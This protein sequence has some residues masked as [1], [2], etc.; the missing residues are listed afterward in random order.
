MADVSA[1]FDARLRGTRSGG[2]VRLTLLCAALIAS[3]LALVPAVPASAAPG[4]VTKGSLGTPR[5]SLAA[6]SGLDGRIYAFGGFNYPPFQEFKTAEVYT[7]ATDSW[8]PIAPMNS[9][10]RSGLG[11]AVD[12]A[13]R[14]YAIGG[15]NS[16]GPFL[17]DVERY[18]P[19]TN[20]WESLPGLSTNRSTVA[21]ATGP[22]GRIY[23]LGG[24]ACCYPVL[25]SAEAF[26]PV[27]NAWSPI[28]SMPTPRAYHAAA[29]ANGR[30]YVFGGTDGVT[31]YGATVDSY[32][33]ATNTWTGRAPMPV[34]RYAPAATTGSDGKIYLL[35]GMTAAGVS[36]DVL[37]YDPVANTWSTGPSLSFGRERLAAA[38]GID[39]TIY[40]IGGSTQY[41][42]GL[43]TVV[44][45]T[46]NTAP[47]VDANGPYAG[48]EGSPVAISGTANDPDAADTVTTTWSYAPGVGVD[49]GAACSFGDASQLS[50]TVTCTDEG[51]YTLILTADDGTNPPVSDTADLT[52]SNVAPTVDITAPAD[53]SIYAVGV[54][55]SVSGTFGDDGTN[56]LG[57]MGCSINWGDGSAPSGGSVSGTTCTSS[58]SFAAAGVY[59]VTLGV[60]DHDGGTASDTV[61]VVVYDPSTG[62]VTGGGWINSPAG[63]YAANPSLTGKANF[64]FVSK[65]QKGATTPTG[66]TEFQFTAGSFNFHSDLYHWLVVSGARAQYKGTGTVNGA[67]GYSFLLTAVDGTPDR[68]RI[69]VW[70]A[71][72]V[73]YDNGLG[74]SDDLTATGTTTSVL[75]GGSIIIHKA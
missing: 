61:M 44:A 23:A 72:G 30:I 9:E 29:T 35:G 18:T 22:D 74:G 48:N 71:G 25:A 16:S 68:F 34:G 67:P 7:P 5:A 59:T 19:A 31:S 75:G 64:G 50:T 40:A 57:G 51:P 54:S 69:K 11:A 2:K 28:A 20:T 70:S 8:A 73:V 15:G 14:I 38:T 32:D 49:G 53:G 1:G 26:N 45:L 55:V 6:V 47:T 42:Y 10:P 56:D 37:V 58:H 3:V 21:T 17:T 12:A 62:F 4:W 36:A 39:G 63:A 33:P 43:S 41:P 46:V 27:T 65:Y 24:Y 66:R 13:G 52:V 60:D